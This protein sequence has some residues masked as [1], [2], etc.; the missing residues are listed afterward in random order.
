MR[1]FKSNLKSD[2]FTFLTQALISEQLLTSNYDRIRIAIVRQYASDRKHLPLS[3]AVA[4]NG[5][6][7]A[8]FEVIS[9]FLHSVTEF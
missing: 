4:Q 2:E 7:Y 1:Y 9:K 8:K 3:Y 5:C 6:S